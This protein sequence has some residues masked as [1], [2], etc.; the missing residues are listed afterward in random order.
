MSCCCYFDHSREKQKDEKVH[1]MV[2]CPRCQVTEFLNLI[3][4]GR[5]R[6][7]NS[8]SSRKNLETAE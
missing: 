4:T 8:R 6:R 3:F 1:P 2:M 5:E 7:R